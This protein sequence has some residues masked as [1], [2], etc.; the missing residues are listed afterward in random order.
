VERL[1]PLSEFDSRDFDSRDFPSSDDDDD[2]DSK[3]HPAYK[4]SSDDNNAGVDGDIKVDI[5]KEEL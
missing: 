3:G 2:N 1:P 4:S 5:R